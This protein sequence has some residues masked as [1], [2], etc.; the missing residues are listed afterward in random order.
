MAGIRPFVGTAMSLRSARFAAS[1]LLGIAGLAAAA[2]VARPRD[3]PASAP[4]AAAPRVTPVVGLGHGGP[5]T[6]LVFSP[7]GRRLATGGCG[8]RGLWLWDAATGKAVGG[9]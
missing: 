3:R 9:L 2:P 5:I 8:D 1:V 4:A 6:H 7:D